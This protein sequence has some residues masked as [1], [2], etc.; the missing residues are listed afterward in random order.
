MVAIK[1]YYFINRAG[2]KLYLYF[3]ERDNRNVN[4][5]YKKYLP[6]FVYINALENTTSSVIILIG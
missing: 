1:I 2:L 4:K 6:F 5:F 3:G